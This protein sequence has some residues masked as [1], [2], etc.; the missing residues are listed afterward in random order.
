MISRSGKDVDLI[1]IRVKRLKI[2]FKIMKNLLCFF[3]IQVAWLTA[4]SQSGLTNF[5]V[6]SGTLGS[7]NSFFG[8]FSGN[9]NLS[10]GNYNSFFGAFS[11]GLNTTGSY[12]TATGMQAL[13]SN[14]TGS[15]NTVT[16]QASLFNNTSGSNNTSHGYAA[17]FSN[18]IGNSNTAIGYSAL[19]FSVNNV[20][21][22]ALGANA[23]RNNTNDLNTAI[24]S[25]ALWSN[26]TG[27]S[28]TAVGQSALVYNV[29]GSNNTAVGQSSGPDFGQPGLSNT[30]A[31]G[32][33][34]RCTA[35]NQV[36]IGNTSVTSIGGQVSWS[37][38]SDGRFKSDIKNNVAGLEFIKQLRPVSYSVD[39]EK[40]NAFLGVKSEE[41][42][43]DARK[44]PI[45]QTGFIA[46]EV[47][48]IV[49]KTG[50]VFHGVEVPQNE[51]DH[52][53][54]RYSEFVVPLVKAVQELSATVD[55]Q[56]NRIDLLVSQIGNNDKNNLE[57]INGGEVTLFQNNPNPFSSDT[58]IK[59]V[60]PESAVKA[61]LIVYNLQ[62]T[63]LK[64]IQVNDR[65]NVSIKILAG[66]LGA[67]MYLYA[68]IVD[69][70]VID[71]KRMI[72]LN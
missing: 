29:T 65:G 16:G 52:Y 20:E 46:Q 45:R 12:N 42:G 68:L 3:L 57:K 15:S 32:A 36:R 23:L 8:Y 62:G 60:L 28:N 17:L 71:T 44:E 54:I 34:T 30:T 72:L 43:I 55:A 69:N 14:T 22:T 2:K 33:V 25:S 13:N 18:T 47:E 10:S 4:F 27:A 35:S 19:Y 40:L 67:G 7:Y 1:N 37:T 48:K 26:T 66:D 11:G 61:D 50:F 56:Q 31:L 64:T 51:N 38:L 63:Q 6:S 58:E 5:G 41:N 49:S 70:K 24:G 53:S 39:K 9:S 21:N 59:M